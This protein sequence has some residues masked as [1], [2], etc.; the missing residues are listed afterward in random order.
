M[1]VMI[2][3]CFLCHLKGVCYF[4]ISA[5]GDTCLY[6]SRKIRP[7]SNLTIKHNSIQ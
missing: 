6:K 1:V 5:A 2:A 4:H 7:I 3:I